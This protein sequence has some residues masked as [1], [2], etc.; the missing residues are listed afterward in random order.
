MAADP[1]TAIE[2][3][4]GDHSDPAFGALN[5]G[6]YGDKGIPSE[7]TGYIFYEEGRAYNDAGSYDKIKNISVNIG[8]GTQRQ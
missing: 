3:G 5:I 2:A 4:S 7:A 1:D 6:Y 8:F